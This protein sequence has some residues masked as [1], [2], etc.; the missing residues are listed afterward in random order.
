ML[1][2]GHEGSGNQSDNQ[3]EG[4][5]TKHVLTI[6]SLSNSWRSRG[7][8][9]AASALTVLSGDNPYYR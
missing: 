3:S 7:Q 6:L 4:G 8:V 5:V 2:A 9:I 1:P